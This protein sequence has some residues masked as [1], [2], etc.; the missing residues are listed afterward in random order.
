MRH[1]PR[2]GRLARAGFAIIS[3]NSYLYEMG[4]HHDGCSCNYCRILLGKC[5]KMKKNER[6]IISKFYFRNENKSNN[7]SA[8]MIPA[9]M[10]PAYISD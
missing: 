4:Y 7:D 2:L 8:S 10:I 5:L 9:S 6:E 3:T 1:G